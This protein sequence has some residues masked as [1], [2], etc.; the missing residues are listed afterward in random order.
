MKVVFKKRS[1][2]ETY[3]YVGINKLTKR[4][5]FFFMFIPYRNLSK[6]RKFKYRFK[7][8]VKNKL[9]KKLK[10]TVINP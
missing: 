6:P 2:W 5:I 8:A 3:I 9:K 1:K 10:N 7:W 4:Y